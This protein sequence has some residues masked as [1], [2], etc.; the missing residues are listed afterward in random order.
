MI[1]KYPTGLY[2]RQLP[3][4]PE[5]AGNVTYTISNE[6]PAAS[7]ESFLLFPIAEQLKRRPNPVWTDEERRAR[8]GE[9]VYSIN[10]GGE[11]AEGNVQKLFEVGQVLEFEDEAAPEVDVDAL[12]K[13]LVMQHNTNLLDF[14][15]LDLD[16]DEIDELTTDSAAAKREIESQMT[17]IQNQIAD[18]KAIVTDLQKK[19]NEANKVLKALNI[20]GDSDEIRTKV[21]KVLNDS[22][23]EQQE[24]VAETN[25]L[26]AQSDAL[27]DQLLSISELVR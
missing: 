16:E 5:E 7:G 26:I 8:L 10:K 13:T 4:S 21:E 18:N 27:R 11:A 2:E 9:L 14:A 6:E 17:A 3:Q 20:L 1:I 22:T 19:I 23:Q 15:G 24:K 25:Q 12:P